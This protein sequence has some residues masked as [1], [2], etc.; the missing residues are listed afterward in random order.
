MISNT[1]SLMRLLME[2]ELISTSM[3]NVEHGNQ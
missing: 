3:I 2:E 1:V